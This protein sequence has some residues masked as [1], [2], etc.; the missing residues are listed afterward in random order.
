M[1][2]P[3]ESPCEGTLGNIKITYLDFV[4]DVILSESLQ[5]LMATLEA[6]SNEAEPMGLEVFWTNI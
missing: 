2:R 5:S 6:F 1:H 3:I 4:D